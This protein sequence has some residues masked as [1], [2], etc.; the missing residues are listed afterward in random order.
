MNRF[1]Q[2][3]LSAHQASWTL[4]MRRE[5]YRRVR[6]VSRMSVLDVG[7]GDGAITSQLAEICKHRVVGVDHDGEILEAAKARG[8]RAEFMK[9]DAYALEF[10][11]SSFDLVT[12]HWLLLWLKDPVAALKEFKRVLK[13]G[14]S[15]LIACEPDYGGRM[16]WPEA[17]ELKDELVRALRA[18][19][20]DPFVGRKLAGLLIEAGFSSHCG[21]YP[22]VWDSSMEQGCLESEKDWLKRVLTGHETEAKI[23]RALSSLDAAYQSGGLMMLT[24]VFWA[25]G[26]PLSRAEQLGL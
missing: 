7:C 21:L 20:A 6:L 26:A 13:A 19:G 4:P 5:L 10:P 18:E 16:V 3:A 9:M 15:L 17:A 14:G 12:C 23:N 22:G 11:E 1:E 25:V 24:P 2:I 8:C